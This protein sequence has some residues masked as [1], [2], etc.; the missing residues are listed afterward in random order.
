[1][2]LRVQVALTAL[3]FWAGISKPGVVVKHG[4][5][6][7]AGGMRLKVIMEV[8]GPPVDDFYCLNYEVSW[9]DGRTSA[10][11]DTSCEPFDDPEHTLADLSWYRRFYPF[12]HVYLSPGTFPVR[13]RLF[14]GSR[15]RGPTVHTWEALVRINPV[16]FANAN[17]R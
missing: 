13:I 4:P 11:E 9:G 6:T 2:S 10:V 1:M 8:T 5:L 14:R 3:L 16:V 12:T 17:N 7:A 15:E